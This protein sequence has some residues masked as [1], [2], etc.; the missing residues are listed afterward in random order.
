MVEPQQGMTYERLLRVG[1]L[2]RQLGLEGLFRSDHYQPLGGE[3]SEEPST[4]A[5]AT[6]A[7]VLAGIRRRLAS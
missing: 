4:D 6:L 3:P 1:R 2:A 5:W 7:G